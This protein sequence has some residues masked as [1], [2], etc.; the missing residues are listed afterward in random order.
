VPGDHRGRVA[1]PVRRRRPAHRRVCALHAAVRRHLLRRGQDVRRVRSGQARPGVRSRT[2][3][4]QVQQRPSRR[5]AGRVDESRR[6]PGARRQRR[7]GARLV[8][9]RQGVGRAK[10]LRGRRDRQQHVR[11]TRGPTHFDIGFQR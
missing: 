3:V 1:G 4:P 5:L 6:M 9:A 8:D 10:G 11:P 2:R 7:H